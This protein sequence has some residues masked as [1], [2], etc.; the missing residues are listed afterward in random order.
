VVW[1]H[2]PLAVGKSGSES[3]L[4]L[5]YH[6]LDI[7]AT[8]LSGFHPLPYLLQELKK[9][10]GAGQTGSNYG[11]DMTHRLFPG[12]FPIRLGLKDASLTRAGQINRR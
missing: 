10:G 9:H 11:K 6:D 7:R 2:K 8:S 4:P 1:H 3:V 5:K 12:L